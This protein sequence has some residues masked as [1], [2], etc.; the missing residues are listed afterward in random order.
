MYLTCIYLLHGF[1]PKWI[2]FASG[3][4]TQSHYFQLKKLKRVKVT[5]VHSVIVDYVF[6]RALWNN[7]QR[8]NRL[9][10]VKQIVTQTRVPQRRCRMRQTMTHFRQD[11]K[12]LLFSR[13]Y[14]LQFHLLFSEFS[15]FSLRLFFFLRTRD[16]SAIEKRTVL[17]KHAHAQAS[18]RHRRWPQVRRRVKV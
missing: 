6:T 2:V 18:P 14:R 9:Q 8:L 10:L 12:S 15:P 11:I 16:E 4:Q 7:S 1:M 17:H 3:L 5:A 13:F